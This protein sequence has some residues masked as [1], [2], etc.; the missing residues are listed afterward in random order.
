MIN[1]AWKICKKS[2]F[3]ILVYFQPCVVLCKGEG[4]IMIRLRIDM[5][6]SRVGQEL[7]WGVRGL[8]IN[9]CTLSVL[10]QVFG[11]PCACNI[12]RW[13]LKLIEVCRSNFTYCDHNSN[14]CYLI[15]INLKGRVWAPLVFVTHIIVI[16]HAINKWFH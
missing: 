10:F 2:V 15:V 3:V 5:G 6:R 16:E 11:I 4:G 13:F 9:L 8:D 1:A 7:I 14:I 12:K